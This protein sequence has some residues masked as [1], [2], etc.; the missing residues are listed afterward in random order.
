MIGNTDLLGTSIVWI[1]TPVKAGAQLQ[2]VGL[3]R[4]ARN[5]R[6]LGNWAPAC[7][8]VERRSGW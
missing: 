2:C 4:A 5:F 6:D 3:Q 1:T 7:A 8:G